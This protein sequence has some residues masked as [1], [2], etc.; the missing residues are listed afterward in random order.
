MSCS[1]CFTGAKH[2]H[3]TAKGSIEYLYDLPAYIALPPENSN[4]KSSIL[5][6]T[7]AFGLKLINSKLLADRYA[8]ETNCKVIMPDVSQP[9]PPNEIFC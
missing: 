3:G 5:F 7:D 8:A 1:A 9:L 6:L 4:P 2:D